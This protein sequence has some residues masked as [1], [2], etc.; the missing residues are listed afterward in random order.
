MAILLGLGSNLGARTANLQ[1][2]LKALEDLDNTSVKAVSHCYETEPW[3]DTDQP[4]FLNIVAEIETALEP[5]ELLNAIQSIETSLG[6]KPSSHWG[7]RTLDIDIILW[8]DL[9]VSSSE[10]TIPHAE[11]RNRAFVLE[12]MAEIAGGVIDPVSKVSVAELSQRPEAEGKVDR[13]TP[14]D[15]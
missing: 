15:H 6:R 2:G 14:L 5:L 10:L 9:I 7:P 3:G 8:N 11:F 4:L 12:P 13:K 1:A